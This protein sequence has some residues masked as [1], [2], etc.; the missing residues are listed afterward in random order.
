VREELPTLHSPQNI[1][2]IRGRKVTG[3]IYENVAP[4]GK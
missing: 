2:V 1:K 3:A 4:E